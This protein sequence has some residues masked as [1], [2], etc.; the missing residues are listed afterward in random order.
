MRMN[1]EASNQL[2]CMTAPVRAFMNDLTITT[3][4]VPGSR[5]IL[6]GL[7]KLITWARMSFKPTKSKSMVLKKEKGVD[8]LHFSLSGTAIPSQSNQPRVWGSSLTQLFKTLP[9]FRSSTK[10]LKPG[11]PRSTIQDCLVDSRPGSTNI[12]SCPNSFGLCWFM[13]L[14]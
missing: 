14:Q 5:W 7:E 1:A 12:P 11:S 13:W 10:T 4:S 9:P 6:Q 8:K 2:R 3:T